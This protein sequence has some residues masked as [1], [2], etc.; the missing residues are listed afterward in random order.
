LNFAPYVK[1][2]LSFEIIKQTT[3][4][5]LKTTAICLNWLSFNSGT[6]VLKFN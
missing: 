3:P 1:T 4:M 2:M 5:R 6:A